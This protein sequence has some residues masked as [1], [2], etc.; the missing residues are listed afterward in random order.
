MQFEGYARKWRGCFE[1]DLME[2]S[3]HKALASIDISS[4]TIVLN[5]VVF[6]YHCA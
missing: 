5:G 2:C 6:V 4:L 1:H 3:G